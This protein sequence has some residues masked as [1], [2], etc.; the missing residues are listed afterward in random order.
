MSE[1]KKI[2]KDSLQENIKEYDEVTVGE[3]QS[4]DDICLKEIKNI[5]DL[6]NDLKG[7]ATAIDM[8]YGSKKT[9]SRKKIFKIKK[10]FKKKWNQ[11]EMKNVSYITKIEKSINP[12]NSQ[13]K[14]NNI[15]NQKKNIIEDNDIPYYKKINN[16]Y[17][18]YNS[19]CLLRKKRKINSKYSLGKKKNNNKNISKNKDLIINKYKKENYIIITES[20]IFQKNVEK[21]Q[22][23]N[24]NSVK[25]SSHS[26]VLI[27]K[28]NSNNEI[29]RK[30]SEP[31]LN[32]KE[33]DFYNFEIL[34]NDIGNDE[35]SQ[36]FNFK[37][38]NFIIK[39]NFSLKDKDSFRKK[40]ISK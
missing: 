33:Q 36:E 14:E 20:D 5:E 2:N 28:S 22:S 40:K 7:T 27:R 30:I 39:D 31:S 26:I 11:I 34:E 13:T 32:L 25:S 24:N 18:D 8:T 17:R 6:K 38:V 29:S 12:T 9:K 21:N 16:K 35:E 37:V 23:I 4:Q 1:D 10:K 3:N 15:I 19:I